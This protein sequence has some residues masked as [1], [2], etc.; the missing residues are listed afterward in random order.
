MFHLVQRH[1]GIFIMVP[2]NFILALLL[3]QNFQSKCFRFDI[4]IFEIT[5][6]THTNKIT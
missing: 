1:A 2:C 4:K 5:P 3:K 6:I